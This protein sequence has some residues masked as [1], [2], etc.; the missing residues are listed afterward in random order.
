ML[1]TAVVHP[2]AFDQAHFATPGYRDQAEMLLR[3]LECNGLLL[4]DPDS[5]LL[6]ELSIRPPP[7]SPAGR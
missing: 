6:N 7:R 1:M 4:L 5:R 2:E 3:G